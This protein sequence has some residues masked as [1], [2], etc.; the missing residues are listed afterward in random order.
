MAHPHVLSS[1]VEREAITEVIYRALIACDRYDTATF[2][3]AWAG[4]DVVFEIHDDE[5]RVLPNLTLIRTHI[6][7]KVG[8][9]DT[10][11]NLSLVRVDVK[12]GADTASLTATS[13]A[14]HCPPGKGRDP[15]GP[16]YTVGGQYSVDLIK[17]EAGEWK[18]K[19]W[20]LNVI[21]SQGDPSVMHG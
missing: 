10:T 2:N 4:E 7:D 12:D 19:K 5:K 14:Q 21:W 13:L 11:H 18:V 20:V 1:L 17:D 16:K 9:M 3:T 15:E 6:L 8:P